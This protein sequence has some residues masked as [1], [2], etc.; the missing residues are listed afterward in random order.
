MSNQSP[1]PDDPER[2]AAQRR[3]YNT[4]A[5]LGIG[6][7]ILIILAL[8]PVPITALYVFAIFI[9]VGILFYARSIIEK[10]YWKKI[11]EAKKAEELRESR[12]EKSV[13]DERKD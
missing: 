4:F 6:V 8:S 12:A 2:Q 3:R 9:V 5:V 11:A 1:S 7:V 10:N 13:Q